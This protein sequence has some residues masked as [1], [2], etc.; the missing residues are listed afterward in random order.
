MES[1]NFSRGQ[2]LIRTKT[3]NFRCSEHHYQLKV[4]QKSVT[5]SKI[6]HCKQM[7]S[8]SNGLVIAKT[9]TVDGVSL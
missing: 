5:L 9:V 6:C 8:I 7:L 4:T 1:I 2:S 3:I